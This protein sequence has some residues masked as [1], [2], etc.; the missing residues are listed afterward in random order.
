MD[1][2]ASLGVTSDQPERNLWVGRYDGGMWNLQTSTRRQ[3]F[4]DCGVG[5][6]KMALASLMAAGGGSHA[7]ANR[8]SPLADNPQGDGEAGLH[9]RPRAKRVIY[10]FMAGAP[11]QLDLFDHK[12][13]LFELEGKPIPAS[14]IGDQRYAFIQPDAA[15]LSPR[16]A[17]ARHGESGVEISEAM[18]RL[19]EVADELAFLK[20]V[21]T[22]QFNHSPAQLFVNTGSGIPGRPA[23]GSWLSYGIGSDASDLPAFIVLKSG[24]NLSG[25][26]A[27]WG[28]GFLPGHHQGVPFRSSGEAILHVDNPSGI[29]R[30]TQK[31]TIDLIG[32]LNR[33]RMQSLNRPAIQ[34]RIESY[35]MAFRMQ[36]RAPELMAI[37]NETERTLHAYGTSTE[38]AGS[39]AKNCLLARRL[40]ERGVRFVQ[41]YHAGWDHHSDVEGG[42]RR[43]AKQVDQACAALIRDLKQRG[44]LD[45]T[46]VVWGG[47]F[48]RTPMVESSGAL[49]RSM[50]RDH[51]PQA[52]TMW[53]AGGG[54]R[55]GQTIGAT[56]ELGFHVVEGATHVHDIQATILHQ[57][58]ID[59]ERLT[60]T[61]A[62]RPFRLTDV[63]GH[64]IRPLVGLS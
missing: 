53:M 5:V 7:A 14:V 57:L 60:F 29:D 30:E 63:H 18:P 8:P 48:G 36:T 54:I 23:M 40:C 21:H 15:V 25:G 47:E 27:M 52:F 49:N 50:G 6:G 16:F 1:P 43:Q 32:D 58:G 17:F 55:S 62:G 19:A 35:E 24:G 31:R 28:N 56:D 10:L 39:F 61:Y 37:E 45:E 2:A 46:L 33:Q 44:M 26:S 3:L 38:D 22:D 13:K 64:V 4:E 42:V 12:P 9:H 51:H 34:T 59:H 20:G 41:V 11:S